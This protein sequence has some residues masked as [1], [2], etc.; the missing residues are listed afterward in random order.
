MAWSSEAIIALAGVLINVPA[1]CLALWQVCRKGHH[2][3][4]PASPSL[5][6]GG[7]EVALL[8]PQQRLTFE[9]GYAIALPYAVPMVNM[10]QQTGRQ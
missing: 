1:F 8:P 6:D 2:H 9:T 3:T 4:N 10:T 5:E 7:S